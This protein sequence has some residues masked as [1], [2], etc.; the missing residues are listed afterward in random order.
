MWDHG[1]LIVISLRTMIHKNSV[2]VCPKNKQ[3]CGL[4]PLLN[5]R[6]QWCDYIEKVM[7]ITNFNPNNT[8]ESSASLNQSIFPFQ[9]CDI[10]LP[11]DQTGFV[12]F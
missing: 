11:Q 8:S 3:N 6:T 12:Y 4:K 9:I 5:Q 10:S 1:Q 2:F 7:K